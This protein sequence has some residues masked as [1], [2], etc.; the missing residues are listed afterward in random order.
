VLHL[1]LKLP[2]HIHMQIVS[3]CDRRLKLHDVLVAACAAMV[4]GLRRFAALSAA[5]IP[6]TRH[7]GSHEAADDAV[8]HHRHALYHGGAVVAQLQHSFLLLIGA[9]LQR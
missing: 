2:D 5:A 8:S 4:G 6:R 1:Q 9:R 7:T 3:A